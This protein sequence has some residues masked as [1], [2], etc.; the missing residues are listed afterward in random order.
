VNI[1]T[2]ETERLILRE[3]RNSDLENFAKFKMNAEAARFVTSLDTVHACWR[4]MA[5]FTGHWLLRGF[6]MWSIELKA[7]GQNI[8][9]CGCYYPEGWPEPEIG[10][11]IFP[12]YQKK[13]FAS[14]A[15]VASIDY[16]YK[17]LG[18]T[19]AISL[20]ANDNHP[21]IALAKR[22]GATFDYPFTYRGFDCSIYR[23]LNPQEFSR[24]SKE[25]LQCQ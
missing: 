7:S 9:H 14:E 2:L 23:H 8:G 20:I 10:W 3:W 21:S 5:Y 6:G 16:A 15:A 13:G 17:K 12:E 19:T 4:E 1:P 18:W 22:L 25:N 11:A 24:H